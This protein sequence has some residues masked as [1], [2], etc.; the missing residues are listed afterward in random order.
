M[1]IFQTPI[2]NTYIPNVLNQTLIS[3]Y[4]HPKYH[5]LIWPF[6]MTMVKMII[7]KQ[8]LKKTLTFNE[9]WL[10]LM[11]CGNN[12][13]LRCQPVLR[14]TGCLL[15]LKCEQNF[16]FRASHKFRPLEGV[17]HL[18]LQL[19]THLIF[20]L[21][22]LLNPVAVELVFNIKKAWACIFIYKNQ[23]FGHI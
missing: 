4:S 11:G 2:L 14:S 19:S 9:Y 5:K 6:K 22:D 21:I 17:I 16:Y 10:S 1:S 20:L 8:P 3:N 7:N 13:M 12:H 23:L 18:Q 15:N